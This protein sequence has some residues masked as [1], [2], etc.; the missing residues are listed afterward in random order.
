MTP[1]DPHDHLS[2]AGDELASLTKAV[3][4]ELEEGSIAKPQ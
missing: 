3:W 1:S 4:H 2:T